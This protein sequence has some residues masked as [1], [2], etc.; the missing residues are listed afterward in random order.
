MEQNVDLGLIHE[1]DPSSHSTIVDIVAVHGLTG[2]PDK[3]WTA[4]DSGTLWLRDFLPKDIPNARIL[5]FR[6]NS[7][8]ASFTT[9]SSVSRIAE[10]LLGCLAE[11]RK[12]S[13]EVRL[14]SYRAGSLLAHIFF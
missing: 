2:H 1:A 5:T 7:S 11:Q 10:G 6:Y 3:T 12:Q 13:Q 14:H 9:R 8:I 4:P